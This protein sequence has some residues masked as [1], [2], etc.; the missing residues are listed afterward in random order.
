MPLREEWI[1]SGT[2]LFKRRSYLPLLLTGLFLIALKDFRYPRHN[3]ALDQLWEFFCLGV[4]FLG[5][6]VRAL[7]IAHTPKGTSGRTT[8]KLVANVLNTTGMYSLVRHPLYLGNFLIWLG[9]SLSVRSW[10]F[11]LMAVLIFWLYCERIMFAEEE[12]LREKF[13][14]AYVKWA[15]KTPAFLPRFK[16]YEP[17]HLPFSFKSILRKEYSGFFGIIALFTLLEIIEERLA[18][19]RFTLDWYWAAFFIFGL[20]VYL[21]LRMLKKSTS[22]LKVEGR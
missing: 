19:G 9:I 1:A 8:E 14:E 11:A 2:W 22:F 3:H 21:I 10:C 7:T 5:L 13:G 15:G 20:V 18:G 6:V 17:P 12:F 16:N 4:S